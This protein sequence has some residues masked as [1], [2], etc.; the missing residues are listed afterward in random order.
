M[1]VKP[2]IAMMQGCRMVFVVS[3]VGRD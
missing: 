2:P 1:T 3:T